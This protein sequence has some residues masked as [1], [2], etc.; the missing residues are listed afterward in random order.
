M[1]REALAEG[2]WKIFAEERDIGLH[3]S[4]NSDLV[5]FIVVVRAVLVVF[6]FFLMRFKRETAIAAFTLDTP[7]S[8]G[9]RLAQRLDTAIA[10]RD[11]TGFEV[12]VDCGAGD[13]VGAFETRGGG[14]GAV[15][16]DEMRG[17]DAGVGF[18]VVDVLSVVC[19]EFGSV[20]KEADEGVGGR[21]GRG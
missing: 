20:L 2:V 6:A 15:A 7:L 5:V 3:H 9:L 4:G 21:E 19:E 10:A 12:G 1:Q 14:E 13:F 17:K 8:A 11:A 18:D 16:L